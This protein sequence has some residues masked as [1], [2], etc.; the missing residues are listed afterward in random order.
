MFCFVCLFV[1]VVVCFGVFWGL[2]VL[3]VWLG[4]AVLCW[5]LFFCDFY[6][7]YVVV[8]VFCV[9]FVWVYF[10]VFVVFQMNEIICC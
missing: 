10:G 1:V 6:L 5:L 9:M 7:F 3:F 2:F 4:G 8:W